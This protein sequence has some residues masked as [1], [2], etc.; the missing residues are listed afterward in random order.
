MKSLEDRVPTEPPC[1][2]RGFSGKAFESSI[3]WKETGLLLFGF[4]LR[5]AFNCWI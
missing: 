3:R 1:W 2:Y 5:E 4:G